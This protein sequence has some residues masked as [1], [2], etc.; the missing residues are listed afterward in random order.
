MRFSSYHERKSPH[1]YRHEQTF[2]A[3]VIQGSECTVQLNDNPQFVA[4]NLV[5]QTLTGLKEITQDRHY[6]YIT[7]SYILSRVEGVV[8][9][10]DL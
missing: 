9:V 5:S 3:E 7:K 2:P 10:R 4:N 1:I 8:C 6:K